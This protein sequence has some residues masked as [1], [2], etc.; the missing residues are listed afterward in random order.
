VYGCGVLYFSLRENVRES[1]VNITHLVYN[2]TRNI[3]KPKKCFSV[4]EIIHLKLLKENNLS[5]RDRM[6]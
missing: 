1:D 2:R 3:L 4:L 5:T 6:A